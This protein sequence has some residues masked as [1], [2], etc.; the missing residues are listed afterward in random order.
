MELDWM[1]ILQ[2][3]VEVCLIPLLGLLTSY[4]I[5]YIKA[6]NKQFKQQVD[7]DLYAKYMDMLEETIVN[8][9]IATNQTY[10]EALKKQN[11]FTA[12]AQKEAF[13][14]TYN[15]VMAILS[16]DAVEYLTAFVGD[17]DLFIKQKI[18][19][20]VSENKKELKPAE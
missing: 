9:V 2:Q 12:E 11:A 4:I 17:L 16:Q 15:A 8:C 10:T 6:K 18:E 14:K 20:E 13:A 1:R 19:A 5:M 7:N 3:V